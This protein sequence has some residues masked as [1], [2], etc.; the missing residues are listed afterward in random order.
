MIYYRKLYSF[1][2]KWKDSRNHKPLVIRGA[3][4]VGKSTLV[5]EFGKEFR[6]SIILNLEKPQ[7]KN[8]FERLD[9]AT[10]IINAIFISRGIPYTKEA[11]LIFIDEIQESPQALKMLRYF[12]E[13]YP[14][15]Y[16]IAAGSLLEFAL[17]PGRQSRSDCSPS[18]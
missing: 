18:V 17:L 14:D 1:L 6:F 7:D 13:E 12:H 15:L 10:D 3:R 16:F 4:Q 5:Q 11:T 9:N 2:L 8:L